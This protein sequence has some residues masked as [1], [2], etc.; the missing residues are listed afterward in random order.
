MDA[1]LLHE[2]E[3]IILDILNWRL[4]RREKDSNYPKV[5]VLIFVNL[6][7][8]GIEYRLLYLERT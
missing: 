3:R 1:R 7:L 8:I 2:T 5:L 6:D 4:G